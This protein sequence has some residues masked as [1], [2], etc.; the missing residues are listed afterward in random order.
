MRRIVSFAMFIVSV[1]AGVALA[2]GQQYG[3]VHG[4]VS[5]QD[6]APLPGVS[7]TVTSEA[8]QGA[9][10]ATTDVNGVYSLPGLAPGNYLVKFELDGMTSVDRRTS[11]SLG[12]TSDVD[13]QLSV[14]P[15]KEAIEVRAS[16]PSPVTSHG[17]A[18]LE[19][20]DLTKLPVGRT[21]FLMTELTPGVTDN[22]P[23]NSQ[24]TIS[25]AFAY[26]NIFLM[27]GVDIND[28]V[29]GTANNLFIEEAIQETQV[30][31]SGVSAEYGRFSGGVVNIIT[32]SG[33]NTLSGAF[34]VNL[35]NPAWSAETPFEKSAGISRASKYSPTFEATTGGPLRR[36]RVW[37]FGAMRVE[38][39]TTQ[40]AF[41]QTRIPYT[42]TND[43][44]RYE[45]KVT[46]TLRPGH[47]LQATL[48]DND[49]D[50][51][52]PSLGSSIDPATMTTPSTPNRIVAANWRG[53]FGARTFAEAQFSDKSWKLENA[54][55][56]SAAIIDSPFLTRGVSGMP[57]NLQYNGP[58]FDSTDP[59]ARN[60]RQFSASVSQMLASRRVGTHE[61][62]TGF[63]SFTSTRV[64]G[65]SQ[66]LSGYVFQTDYKVA[67]DGRP[68]LD[69]SGRLIPR[70]VPGTSRLQTWMPLRGSS[71][72][73][74]TTSAYINDRWT[75]NGRATFELGLRYEHAASQATGDIS[76]ADGSTLMPRLGAAYD[77]T[78]DGRTVVHATYGHYSGKYN[79]VQFSRNS[80]VGNADRITG[81][82]IGPA[83]EGREFVAGFDPA[84]YQTFTGTFPTA[85][86]FFED[87]LE[88]PLTREFTL[89]LARDLR[90][91]G[92]ARVTYVN[93]HATNF[94]EDFITMAEGQTIV[95]KNGVNLGAFDNAVYRNTNLP[96]RDYRA[97]QFEAAYRPVVNLSVNGHW[98]VQLENDGTFEGE[99]SSGP[100]Q[101]SLIAD[102]PEIYVPLRSFPDGRLD[103]FQ[104]NKVRVWATYQ[105]HLGHFGALDVAPLYRYN[106][107]RTY[108]LVASGVPLS[109]Q[110]IARNPGYA[111]L[112]TSQSIFFGARGSQSFEGYHLVDLATTYSVPVWQSL[113]PW[114]K[115]EILNAFNNQKLV[116]WNTSITADN[117][118]PKDENGLPTNYVKSA[119]FGTATGPANY[120]R[121]RPGLDG[122][123]TLL[124][125]AGI[126]F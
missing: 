38:R 15:V 72:D 66:S 68:E 33:G 90:N 115:L 86:V 2:Q 22:T 50:L 102:Y 63:E 109:S 83:G 21:P 13:Q 61:L 89:G 88:S 82:Y 55:G 92:W 37:L 30:L 113:R 3:S 62:K 14:A 67:A 75:A 4:R 91:R 11:V 10:T 106:S 40:S 107:G 118:G 8:I 119:A 31:S 7:V 110:Q 77:V 6:N 121:P 24:I 41:A 79:D 104:R 18:N 65:N 69:A 32:R 26:D 123:R 42:A 9:R 44:T 45:G 70:F 17:T 52:Q 64:G 12:T 20:S 25:G 94:V 101:P 87:G 23:S 71:I 81:T 95:S 51:R 122:G 99:S 108:S 117:S 85:N 35:T 98:T 48:I 19:M 76:G 16:T 126:R 58:Y 103:D 34:R 124:V 43:N 49:T 114:V 78:A 59:E 53:A 120:P 112:P 97:M 54:G 84:N 93:R 39:T 105:L 80:N 27:D 56:T 125:A 111:R 60:N 46:A 1:S 74:T 96:T 36:D 100:A 5:S 29:L 47:T 116:S 73:V 28:N 57:A